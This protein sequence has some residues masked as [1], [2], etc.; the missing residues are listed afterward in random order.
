MNMF[1]NLPVRSHRH[2]GLT[3]EGYSRAAVQSYWRCPELRACF[4]LGGVP[5]AFT[6]TQHF[7]VTHAHLDH[8]SGLPVIVARRR[9]MKMGPT[10]I[11]MPAGDVD[12]CRRILDLWQRLDR[13]R[14]TCELIG[15]KPGDQ[16]ELSREHVVEVF[17]TTHSVPS[18][19][20]QVWER[21]KKLKPELVGLPQD[22]IRDMKLAGAVVDQECRI[23]LLCYTGDTTPEALDKYAPA[24]ESR[25]LITEMS[26]FHPDH[27]PT[28]VHKFGHTHMYDIVFRSEKFKNELIILSHFSTRYHD[29]QFKNLVKEKFPPSLQDRVMLWM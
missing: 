21:K 4:D 2:K 27:I 7:F 25:I 24:F 10:T 11:Y 19:G 23:P 6:G 5:W 9:M 20:Y 12:L 8:L 18:V 13:G 14:M 16:I 17:E 15:V 26:F 1:E 3:I 22:Q 29:G 28:K